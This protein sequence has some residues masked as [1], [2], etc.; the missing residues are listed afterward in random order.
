MYFL[1]GNQSDSLA[2][3]YVLNYPTASKVVVIRSR[4]VYMAKA[5][6][7]SDGATF[8]KRKKN[9]YS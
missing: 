1:H 3:T 4:V 6:I 2:D 8:T 7:K 9:K 5:F